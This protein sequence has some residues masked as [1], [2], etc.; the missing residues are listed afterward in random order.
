ME[1]FDEL[2]SW[3]SSWFC[4]IGLILACVMLHVS[5]LILID[6][7]VVTKVE[8]RL[9]PWAGH[10]RAPVIT[11]AVILMLTVLH[12]LEAFL[13]A[14]AYRLLGALPHLHGAILFS[15]GALTTYGNSDIDIVEH[16]RLLGALEALNG[17]LLFGLSTAFVFSVLVR[18]WAFDRVA[19]RQTGE[20][21]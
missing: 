16:W 2:G 10:A 11:S 13:W 3:A 6:L 15:L 1:S 17:S 7:R 21:G 14:L 5:G 18:N 4:G 20:G 8:R 9:P 12:G 19:V